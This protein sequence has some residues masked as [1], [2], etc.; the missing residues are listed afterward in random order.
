MTEE[1]PEIHQNKHDT[2]KYA[3]LGCVVFNKEI[4]EN[5]WRIRIQSIDFISHV[6]SGQ[7]VMLRL[8]EENDPLLGRPFAVYQID[9]STGTF[10]V[11]YL[12]VGKMTK[13][14][15]QIQPGQSLELW[16][17][18]GNGW[19]IPQEARNPEKVRHFIMV[20][21]GIGQTPFYLFVQEIQAEVER[22]RQINSRCPNPVF[23]LLFGARTARRLCC[24]EEFRELGVDVC[25]V[26]EDGS[27]GQK[28]FATDYLPEAVARIR[29]VD[30]DDSE[31]KYRTVILG[32]GP[33]PM[34]RSLAQKA[35]ELQ[36]PAWVSLE[37]PMSCG[38]G[39][40]FGCVVEWKTDDGTWDYRRT[41]T[42]GP[43]FEASRLKWD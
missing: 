23:T 3:G 42:D 32:C 30:K 29:S 39:I 27:L 38:L 37:S 24:M 12:V 21:G 2:Q 36:L 19:N 25:P 34:L 9:F 17:G 8:P 7:F 28:G 41:C 26:T 33:R 1:N 14:L 4:A 16:G 43:V 5:T 20:A 18:L 6:K 13:R 10:D 22:R 15:T 31:H 40:C 11:I 35:E